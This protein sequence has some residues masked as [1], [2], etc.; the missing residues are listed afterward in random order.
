MSKNRTERSREDSI[1]GLE[2]LMLSYTDQLPELIDGLRYQRKKISRVTYLDFVSSAHRGLAAAEYFTNKNLTIFKQNMHVCGL[3]KLRSLQI[4]P[5]ENRVGFNAPRL[6]GVLMDALM[7]DNTDLIRAT[8]SIEQPDTDKTRFVERMWKAAILGEDD[9]VRQL[10][11]LSVSRG[12]S[13]RKD[14]KKDVEEGRDFFSLLLARDEEGLKERVIKDI[15]TES[16]DAMFD[17]F[18]SLYSTA[19]AKLCHI[20]GIPVEIDHPRVPM[21]LVRIAPL[22]HYDDVYDFLAPD[23]KPPPEGLF[24]HLKSWIKKT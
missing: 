9:L 24:G 22:P 16:M 3:C 17:D 4:T 15:D 10:L 19:L 8:A 7:S 1:A 2:R 11:P 14:Y 21:D 23:Y 13:A 5:Y 6:I 12:S 18:V 20:R